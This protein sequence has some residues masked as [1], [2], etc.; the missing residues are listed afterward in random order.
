ME[1]CVNIYNQLLD[2]FKEKET[3]V[4]LYR[5]DI[6]TRLNRF[7]ECLKNEDTFALF[8]MYKVKAFSSKTEETHSL[9][10][11]LFDENFTLKTIFNNKQDVTK[12]QLW[13]LLFNLYIQLEKVH[14]PES[15]R[16]ELLKENLKVV[17]STFASSLKND[18]FKNN[19]TGNVNDKTNNMLDEIIGSFQSVVNNN[20]NPFD[21]IMSITE[22]ISQKYATGI[23]TGDIQIDKV[24]GGMSDLIKNT[25]GA[26]GLGKMGDLANMGNLG[27]LAKMAGFESKKETVVIDENFSTGAVDVGKEDESSFN[28]GK[29]KPLA[30][31]FTGLGG[32]TSNFG[33]FGKGDGSFDFSKLAQMGGTFDFSKLGELAQSMTDG[34][35]DGDELEGLKSMMGSFMK[36]NLNMDMDKITESLHKNAD[37]LDEKK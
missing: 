14:N 4:E 30:D 35:M 23:E 28:L 11:S 7:Y 34:S 13:D 22:K 8:S 36:E 33:E 32:S 25:M 10:L 2:S 27:D 20:G 5:T 24:L 9:S 15:P 16:I 18:I 6:P 21:S 3:N 19:V 37:N 26:N 29:L 31:M 12:M 1:N 17:R